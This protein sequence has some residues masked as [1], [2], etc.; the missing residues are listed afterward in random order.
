MPVELVFKAMFPQAV[1][2]LGAPGGVTYEKL[3]TGLLGHSE[4]H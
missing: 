3:W 2:V 4:D 1:N